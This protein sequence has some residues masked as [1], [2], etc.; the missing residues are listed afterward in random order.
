MANAAAI[1]ETSTSVDAD[2]GRGIPEDARKR[3]EL[4]HDCR[5]MVVS[6]L[7]SVI[8]DALARLSDELSELAMKTGDH[9]EQQALMDALV[10]VR[11]N[12]SDIEVRFRKAFTDCFERRMFNNGSGAK[13][14]QPDQE[15]EL[16]L[17]DDS[18]IR[19]QLTVDRLVHRA[20]GKLDP[21]EVLGIRARLA[22]LLE[23]DWFDEGQH[24]A[25]PEA[26]FEA[27]RTALA[28]IAPKS[29]VQRALLDAFEPHVSASLNK[30][31]STVNDRLKANRV[32][33]RI[34]PQV[35]VNR[36][37]PR[38]HEV[39]ANAA[40][41]AESGYGPDAMVAGGHPAGYS[42]DPSAMAMVASI[43]HSLDQLA[44]GVPAARM[45]VARML[46]DPDIFGVAD[47]P[48][49]AAQSS[50]IESINHL[51]SL[52]SQRADASSPVNDLIDKAREKGSPLDQLTVE[53]VS[54][55]FDYIYA[56]KRLPDAIK[57]Q[58]LRL[59]V[60]A[61]KAALLDRSFF[62]RRQ[63]P[64]RKLIDR[65]T[66]LATDP[67]ADLA[68][69]AAL[70]TELERVVNSIVTTFDKDL[71]IFDDALVQIEKLAEVEAARRGERLTQLTRDAETTEA[72]EAAREQSRAIISDRMDTGTP[73]FVRQFLEDWWSK[74]MAAASVAKEPDAFRSADGLQVAEA[75]IWSVAPKI[76]D[77]ISR[78]A[79][80]LPKLIGGLMRGLKTIEM[81]AGVRETFFNELLRVHTKGIESAKQTLAS[82]NSAM[83]RP[84]SRIRMRSDGSILYTAP[85]SEA[86]PVVHKAPEVVNRSPVIAE[87]R[88]GDQIEVD[89]DGEAKRFKLAWISPT[90]KLYI[91]T[92]FPNEA[93]SLEYKQFSSMFESGAARVIE[94]DSPVD[95]AIDS[96]AA[97]RERAT[98]EAAG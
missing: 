25:A 97:P 24:P 17:V 30:V 68:P 6:R 95:N 7:S 53:I 43:Q 84:V 38:R 59:Q 89:E 13:D 64:M 46:T 39:G 71:S 44:H 1:P 83:M 93:R 54:L 20:R 26:V 41:S 55:V 50:L 47:L 72:L 96:I 2:Q 61:V 90:Q 27:L 36:T 63:H 42:V 15:V 79:T 4:L 76:P 56:D 81:P 52:S 11:Q 18:V 92:R 69:D 22:A 78:L 57:Q 87:I 14:A 60:V 67:D 91:L 12:R 74:V 37:G 65:I 34:K 33:P 23:R 48:L 21:D 86:G 82:R 16:C 49:P 32:L 31:Y 3:F 66:E 40:V 5:E 35:A 45:S 51:Q 98:M 94:R 8:H 70:P 10:V 88:R 73:E 9:A 58:L 19:D 28:E 85:R 29:D 75:L 62:A 80:L 77:E